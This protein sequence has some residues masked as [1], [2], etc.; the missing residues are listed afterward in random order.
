MKSTLIKNAAVV[1]SDGVRL[2]NVLIEN[3]KIADIDYKGEIYENIEVVDAEGNY[4]LAGFIDLHVHGGGGADFMDATPEAFETAVKSHLKHGTTLL[5][6]TAVSATYDDYIDFINAFKEF[7]KISEY[8]KMADSLHLEGPYFFGATQSSR[9]AQ[10]VSVLR[11]PDFDEIDRLL[12]LADG[13]ITRWDASPELEGALEFGEKMKQNGI[14]CSVAHTDATAEQAEAAFLHGFSHVT[15]F[16][17]ANS[18]H[19][20]REQTVY[21]GVVEATYLDDN[22]TV[23][24]I[25]DGC[26]IPKQDIYLALKIKG[27]D[28]VSVI[29]DAMRIAGTDMQSGKLGSLKAGSEVIVDADVAKLADKV[30]F[31]GSIATMDRCLRTLVLKYGIDMSTASCLL[32]LSPAKCMGIADKKGSIEVGKDADLVLA[33]KNLN[34][35]N[36]MVEG[37]F[38]GENL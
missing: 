24:L 22:V 27:V 33:D 36:V 18:M 21:A 20:K 14:L 13:A 23:E 5:Y 35:V 34:I 11:L 17:N 38:Y 12:A 4:L 6:P 15:H 10:N 1:L 8:G 30:S 9:G 16:Y 37:K 29:T 28:K 19:R 26:H 2:S 32:S 25:G 31:A 7:K 3:G